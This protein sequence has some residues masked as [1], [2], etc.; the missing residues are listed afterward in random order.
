MLKRY[1]NNTYFLLSLF[2]VAFVLAT[3]S[4]TLYLKYVQKIKSN[5]SSAL[6]G[7][8]I[9]PSSEP[10]TDKSLNVLLLGYGG[11]EHDGGSLTD[12]ITLVNINPESK[13]FNLISIPRDL[14]VPIPTDWDNTTYGKINSAYAIGLD[15]TKYPN[16]KPE[17]RG[18]NGGGSLAKYA[19]GKITGFNIDYFISVDFDRF[20]EIIDLIGGI[21][22][23]VPQTYDDNFY[24]LKGMENETCG[25][26]EKEIANFHKK[27]SDFELEKQFTCRYERLHFDKGIVKLNGE[28]ALKFVRSRHGDSDFGRSQRQHAVLE[29]IGNK[30]LNLNILH[31]A[32]PLFKTLSGSVKSDLDMNIL[33]RIVEPLGNITQYKTNHIYL[34]DQ[35]VLVAA[36]A[37]G[38]QYILNPKA[39][40]GN[41]SG[42]KDFITKET[43]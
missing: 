8:S 38:G 14:W 25:F 26:S 15:Q 20:S 4:T 30:V 33:P 1:L 23:N 28:T 42:I 29:A 17:F 22:V 27:Y 41:Y 40:L 13:K 2:I 11:N 43:N 37:T 31:S 5:S 34:T 7:E 32:N 36:K 19:V 35:N 9:I 39:G 18:E 16:K 6:Q 3:I 10:K 21:E 24:P 12:S